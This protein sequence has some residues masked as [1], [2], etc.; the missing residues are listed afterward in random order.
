VTGES[1]ERKQKSSEEDACKEMVTLRQLWNEFVL[2]TRIKN[3]QYGKLPKK[4]CSCGRARISYPHW[5]PTSEA[6]STEQF[7]YCMDDNNGHRRNL[8]LR[9][10]EHFNE[11]ANMTNWK[12][13]E[14]QKYYRDAAEMIRLHS[15]VVRKELERSL[16]HRKRPSSWSCEKYCEV[17]LTK[18]QASC[19]CHCGEHRD[20][21]PVH[22]Y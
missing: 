15:L 5:P 6:E 20:V 12:A 17:V 13:S 1:P 14:P 3:K 8:V 22:S 7:N 11:F 2:A 16:T 21:C 9:W 4:G 10:W 18:R 19:L